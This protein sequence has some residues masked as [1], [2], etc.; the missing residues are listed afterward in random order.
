M[1]RLY[2]VLG[3]LISLTL[4]MSNS[5]NPPNGKSG[6]PGDELCTDCHSLDGGTQNG[7]LV[8]YGFPAVIEPNTT[9]MLTI[10]NSNPNGVAVKGGFQLTILN[11]NNQKAGDFV[12]GSND[13]SSAIT[14]SGGRQ[15]WE[16]DPAQDY[17]A[18]MRRNDQ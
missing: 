5:A 11:S 4:L 2:T 6:A 1:S 7:T 15:Y 14:N 12:T 18:A 8:L 3:I 17:P 16:H 13:P 10:T 9:Y